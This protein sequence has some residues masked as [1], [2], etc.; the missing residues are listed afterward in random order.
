MSKVTMYRGIDAFD[1]E[2]SLF[3][4]CNGVVAAAYY[5]DDS[6]WLSPDTFGEF[7]DWHSGASGICSERYKNLHEMHVVWES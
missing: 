1:G 7:K 6:D 3:A 2:D 5:T 4:V